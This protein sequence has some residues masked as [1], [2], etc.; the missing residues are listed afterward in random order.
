MCVLLG[1]FF[2]VCRFITSHFPRDQSADGAWRVRT[3]ERRKRRRPLARVGVEAGVKYFES[4]VTN[5]HREAAAVR[6]ERNCWWIY[7]RF[8]LLSFFSCVCV[9][10][11]CIN[12]WNSR[13]ASPH[14]RPFRPSSNYFIRLGVTLL[15]VFAS[16][17]LPSQQQKQNNKLKSEAH[18]YFSVNFLSLQSWAHMRCVWPLWKSIH[19]RTFRMAV[20]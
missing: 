6:G 12:G 9:C 1:F 18:I 2:S 11:P 20:H 17:R 14:R 5:K 10:V 4:H 7:D 19:R 8:P 15:I 13:D 16:L 3:K